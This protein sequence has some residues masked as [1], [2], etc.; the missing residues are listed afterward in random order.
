MLMVVSLFQKEFSLCFRWII[1]L[2]GFFLNTNYW[3]NTDKNSSGNSKKKEIE[4]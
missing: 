3:T 4:W 1:S 2:D